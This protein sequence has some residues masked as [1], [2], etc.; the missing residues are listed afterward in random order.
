MEE[1]TGPV[2]EDGEAGAREEGHGIPQGLQALP[3]CGPPHLPERTHE[4]QT[5]VSVCTHHGGICHRTLSF[6]LLKLFLL[7]P[8][9]F[10]MCSL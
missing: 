9:V 10:N 2:R 6:K 4:S 5:R 7:G 3:L 8:E 1:H